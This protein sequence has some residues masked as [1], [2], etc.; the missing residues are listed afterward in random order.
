MNNPYEDWEGAEDRDTQ[1]QPHLLTVWEVS[2]RLQLHTSTV[3]RLIRN[4]HLPVV[5]I[6]AS[7]L[8]IDEADLQAWIAARKARSVFSKA[9]GRSWEYLLREGRRQ[10]AW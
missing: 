10:G 4:G 6:S 5:V 3:Y 2:Q 8:R 1:E 7:T 9:K